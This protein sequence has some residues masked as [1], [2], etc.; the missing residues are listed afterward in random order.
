MGLSSI[1][2]LPLLHHFPRKPKLRP[3]IN[4]F[5][6]P[7]VDFPVPLER[8]PHVVPLW[9][10]LGIRDCHGSA[11]A[12][13]A[14]LKVCARHLGVPRHVLLGIDNLLGVAHL[15]AG[16]S[17]QARQKEGGQG[18]HGANFGFVMGGED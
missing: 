3:V 2:H 16:M 6:R 14:L 1:A 13:E 8:V 7:R 17:T 9:Q 10:P 5:L 12:I 15:R 4:R 18:D 11:E